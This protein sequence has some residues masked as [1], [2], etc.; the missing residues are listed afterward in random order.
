MDDES[1]RA[2]TPDHKNMTKKEKEIEPFVKV[3]LDI[4]PFCSYYV[5]HDRRNMWK[6]LMDVWKCNKIY[7]QRDRDTVRT[8]K[9]LLSACFTVDIAIEYSPANSQLDDCWVE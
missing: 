8:L 6:G 4:K 2:V 1:L 9:I 5:P 3:I 7:L